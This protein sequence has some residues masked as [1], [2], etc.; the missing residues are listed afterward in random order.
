MGCVVSFVKEMAEKDGVCKTKGDLCRFQLLTNSVEKGSW[1][2]SNSRCTIE[3]LSRRCYNRDGQAQNYTKKFVLAVFKGLKREI[4]SV[5]VVGSMELAV[6][7][8]E[9]NVLELDRYDQ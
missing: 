5:K 3:E 9:P 7:R 8:E 4:D 2:K 6:T 1:F